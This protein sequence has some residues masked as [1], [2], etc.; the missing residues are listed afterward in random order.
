MLLALLISHDMGMRKVDKSWF[1]K[2]EIK[3]KFEKSNESKTTHFFGGV[4]NRVGRFHIGAEG[5][6]YTRFQPGVDNSND[7]RRLRLLESRR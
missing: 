5:R 4:R 7:H 1:D 3:Y 6:G 2:N